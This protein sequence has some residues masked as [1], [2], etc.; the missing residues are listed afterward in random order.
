M[1]CTTYDHRL[2]KRHCLLRYSRERVKFS[3]DSNYRFARSILRHK[4]GWD[5]CYTRSNFESRITEG[6]L[7]ELG[8]IGLQIAEFWIA[9]NLTSQVTIKVSLGIQLGKHL[10]FLS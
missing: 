1:A 6:L 10:F 2:T 7:K 9:P 5:T 8:T 4:S 3:H